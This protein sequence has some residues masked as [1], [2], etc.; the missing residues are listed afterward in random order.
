MCIRD[1]WGDIVTGRKGVLHFVVILFCFIKCI[2][3]QRRKAQLKNGFSPTTNTVTKN[4]G[5]RCMFGNAISFQE[6]QCCVAHP[7]ARTP[8]MRADDATQRRA[9]PKKMAK[10][11]KF[12][13]HEVSCWR[14]YRQTTPT[15]VM[16][17]VAL[18]YHQPFGNTHNPC[19]LCSEGQFKTRRHWFPVQQPDVVGVLVGNALPSW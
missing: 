2:R 11:I 19:S 6:F 13:C 5:M 12:S 15:W 17:L 14:K 7:N 8:S 10:L 16:W 18:K 9:K 3:A 4:S 1:R